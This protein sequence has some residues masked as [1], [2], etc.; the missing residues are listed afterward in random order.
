MLAMA[1]P[2][3]WRILLTFRFV[4]FAA[5]SSSPSGASHRARS[6]LF[7][8]TPWVIPPAPAGEEGAVQ[9]VVAALGH[10][11]GHEQQTP[12]TRA[13]TPV[14]ALTTREAAGWDTPG[15]DG[16]PAGGSLSTRLPRF[17]PP[18]RGSS[19]VEATEASPFSRRRGRQAVFR[20]I[21]RLSA[22]S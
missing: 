10:L 4:S 22:R 2:T 11:L 5:S 17:A 19:R 18:S 21:P 13:I 20:R 16:S 6:F 15:K 8:R 1:C 14:R 3:T 7:P 12:G 9:H